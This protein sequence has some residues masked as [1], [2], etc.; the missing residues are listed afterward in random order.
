[1][2]VAQHAHG[3]EANVKQGIEF[4]LDLPLEPFVEG[5]QIVWRDGRLQTGRQ[6]VRG[7]YTLG[8]QD[9][10]RVRQFIGR[11]A[12]ETAGD[13]FQSGAT[14]LQL[15]KLIGEL[16]SQSRIDAAHLPED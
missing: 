12:T 15:A 7:R 16:S 8:Q 10:I 11:I 3:T 6:S 13:F 1:L 5:T 9:S 14:E 2:Q 4:L